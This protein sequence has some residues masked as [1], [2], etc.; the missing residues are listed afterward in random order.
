LAVILLTQEVQAP[1]QRVKISTFDKPESGFESENIMEIEQFMLEKTT[2]LQNSLFDITP[3]RTLSKKEREAQTAA[4]RRELADEAFERQA[5]KFKSAFK[6]YFEGFLR[7]RKGEQFSFPDV[8]NGY[9]KTSNVQP[10]LDFRSVGG[11]CLKYIRL[12]KIEKV[13]TA[14]D[15]RSGR[16]IPVYLVL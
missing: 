16:I 15:E 4:H 7:A 5:D 8:T 6:D 10:R 1:A 13:G 14:T 12:G 2:T 3:A 11:I 9:A